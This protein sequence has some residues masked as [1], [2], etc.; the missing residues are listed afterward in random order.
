MPSGNEPPSDEAE[1]ARRR[2]VGDGQR[3]ALEQPQWLDESYRPKRRDPQG[4][5][6]SIH[7]LLV[8]IWRGDLEG[9]GTPLSRGWGRQDT[10][11]KRVR[12]VGLCA[13][14]GVLIVAL[15]LGW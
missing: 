10:W 14:P 9:T 11:W 13:L 7:Q 12:F 5:W 6:E 1:Q 2:A 4:F 3:K 15:L 8:E